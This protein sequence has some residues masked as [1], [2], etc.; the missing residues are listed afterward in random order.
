MDEAELLADRIAIMSVGKLQVCGSGLFLKNKYGLGYN[1]TIVLAAGTPLV[2]SR[3]SDDHEMDDIEASNR[4]LTVASAPVSDGILRFLQSYIPG[5]ELIRKSG[6]ELTYRFPPDTD[7]RFADVFDALEEE[8]HALNV[9]AFGISNSSLEEV[10]LQLA[11]AD[12]NGNGDQ[13]AAAIEAT[14]FD[15]SGAVGVTLEGTTADAEGSGNHVG[16][17]KILS[18]SSSIAAAQLIDSPLTNDERMIETAPVVAAELH[19]LGPARQIAL[20]YYKRVVVQKRDFKGFF[21]MIILPVIVIGLVLLILMIDVPLAGPPIEV[22]MDLYGGTDVVVGG[23]A[24]LSQNDTG[25]QEIIVDAYEN[26][27]AILREEYPDAG[28][29][30]IAKAV[31]SGEISQYLLETYNDR[32]HN[33]RYGAFVLEDVIKL[34]LRVDWAS[35]VDDITNLNVMDIANLGG[36]VGVGLSPTLPEFKISV[37]ELSDIIYSTGT[38]SESSSIDAV[39]IHQGTPYFCRVTR[40]YPHFELTLSL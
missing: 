38:L 29:S 26:L 30:R 9:D 39:S 20:L 36:F 8:R 25:S 35:V 7:D 12:H 31:S 33:T 5:T 24:S 21:F 13:N 10:F 2:A 32:D 4:S 6:R 3:S 15:D 40:F 17:R 23:G 1:L 16:S 22:S 37:Q 11:E 34:K 28:F 19:H 14:T 18:S 27:S